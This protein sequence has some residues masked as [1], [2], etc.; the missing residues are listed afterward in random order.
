MKHDDDGQ[1]GE[2]GLSA[3]EQQI[4]ALLRAVRHDASVPDHLARR[5][6][7]TLAGLRDDHGA[8][9]ERGIAAGAAADS[10]P[11]TAWDAAVA[12][13]ARR[14]PARVV[15]GLAAGVAAAVGIGGIVL[16]QIT[17]GSG[18]DS[19]F[20]SASQGAPEAASGEAGAGDAAG[21][22]ASAEARAD[23]DS[24]ASSSAAGLPRLR[25]A[26]FAAD[27]TDVLAATSRSDL[28]DSRF[29]DLAGAAAESAAEPSASP[30]PQSSAVSGL[31]DQEAAQGAGRDEVRAPADAP[32]TSVD[33]RSRAFATTNRA[34][35]DAGIS[36]GP[37]QT[38][39]VASLGG[40][41][42]LVVAGPARASAYACSSAADGEKR[43]RAGDATSGGSEA[44][45]GVV[46]EASEV[47]L[48]G[49]RPR[50]LISRPLG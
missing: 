15:L 33:G 42:V 2:P 43:A 25:R 9:T 49:V 46:D 4:Q 36:P 7:D 26:S 8:R 44:S 16:P 37:R 19:G 11:S 30:R 45:G 5:L 14:Q 10:A 39:F 31:L 1:Q 47:P 23:A 41:P 27:V 29:E 28:A 18:S 32:L 40:R 38:A 13:R 12:R 35:C 22:A 20:A 17:A 34:T 3:E 50:P 21:G 24:L 6:D 48:L